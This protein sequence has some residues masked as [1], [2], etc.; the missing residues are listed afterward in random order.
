MLKQYLNLPRQIHLLCLG[1]FVNRA[2]TFVVVFLTIYLTQQLHLDVGFATRTIGL[3]GLG[4][5]LAAAIGGHLADLI[6]R[7]VVMLFALFGG[8]GI[9]VALSFVTTPWLIMVLVPLFS[10]IGEMYRP[11]CSA[12]IA[13]LVP[14]LHRPAA[15]SLMI[16]SVNL[17]FA[18]GASVGG[19]IAKYDFHWLFWCDAATSAIYG[20]IVA[21]AIGETLPRLMRRTTGRDDQSPPRQGVQTPDRAADASRRPAAAAEPDAASDAAAPVPLRAAVRQILTNQPFLRFLLGNFFIALVFL[22]ATSTFP[23]YLERRG[24]APDD[25]GLVI[26]LNGL[27]IV[28]LQ[29]PLISLLNRFH[30]GSVVVLATVLNAIGFGLNAYAS[31]LWQFAVTTA[32]WTLGEMG[33]A[34]YGAVIVSDFAPPALR[35]RYMGAYGM[36]F[37]SAMMLAAPL[38]G[39]ILSRPQLGPGALWYAAFLLSMIAALLYFSI[40][41]Q[42]AAKELAPR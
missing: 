3:Y 34:C 29:I 40:R 27:L 19:L 4:T 28:V 31:A 33:L 9:L 6:G 2:G 36:S 26:S 24:F 37:S 11:A 23:L 16:V 20:I 39:A 14:P 18:V 7:R 10:V 15:F 35:A 38:G 17:G 8:G 30:R 21:A 5:V 42:L 32:V 1:T 25:Y 41:R 12:M 13:D 22:Q